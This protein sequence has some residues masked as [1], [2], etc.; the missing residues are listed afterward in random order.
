M[1]EKTN[2]GLLSRTAILTAQDLTYEDVHVPE[3]GGMVRVK[4]LTGAERDAFEVKSLTGKGKNR[5]VNIRNLRAR[6]VQM[7]VIDENGD[8]LFREED[9]LTL[10]S[11]SAA[12]LDRVFAASQ[13]LSR[14]TDEDV[15]E[16]VSDFPN[17][18]SGTSTS[19]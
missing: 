11:K 5:E 18:P 8:L 10:G 2:A 19:G 6:L 9:V 16:L 4:G 7:S 15:D 13:K 14:L 3:W 17:D 12:A 1:S